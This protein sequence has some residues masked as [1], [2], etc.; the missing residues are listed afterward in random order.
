MAPV[1]CCKKG[2][3]VTDDPTN[4]AASTGGPDHTFTVSDAYMAQ[5][6]GL[7]IAVIVVIAAVPFLVLVVNPRGL[8]RLFALAPI[9]LLLDVAVIA[10]GVL[11]TTYL[12]RQLR[13]T[14][15]VV[16]AAGLMREAGTARDTVAWRDVT[17]VRVRHDR[18]SLPIFIEVFRSGGG[19]L[20]LFGFDGMGDLASEV[21]THIPPT[22]RYLSK[23]TGFINTPTGRIVLLVGVVIGG[24]A[25]NALLGR[26][27]MDRLNGIVSLGLS[28]WMIGFRPTARTNP[29]FRFLDLVFGLFF[30][31]SA[32]QMLGHWPR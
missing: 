24:L 7:T 10:G 25:L 9:F 6:R 14:I 21:R 32:W 31:L 11:V 15:L 30:L 16:G 13:R 2:S 22:A 28:G 17:K 4:S 3:F 19:P 23:G 8:E 27:V 26:A 18:E 20:Q 12:S 5:R 29:S 1:R